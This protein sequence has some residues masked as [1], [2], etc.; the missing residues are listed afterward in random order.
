MDWIQ[1]HTLALYYQDDVG[2]TFILLKFGVR[3]T[4]NLRSES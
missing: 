1:E 2:Q 3:S 4:P